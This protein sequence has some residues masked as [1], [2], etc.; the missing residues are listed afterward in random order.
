MNDGP[1]PQLLF[2]K[3]WNN[4]CV[5][6][7]GGGYDLV[8][9]DRHMMHELASDVAFSML[10]ARGH[11]VREMAVKAIMETT[12]H[13]RIRRGMRSKHMVGI[14]RDEKYFKYDRPE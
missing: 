1:R 9:I 4:H 13:G 7:L 11:R 3:I 8:Y 5:S 12:S 6:S 10:S 2:D 14:G